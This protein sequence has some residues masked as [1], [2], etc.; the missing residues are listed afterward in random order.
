[1]DGYHEV[2]LK[3]TLNDILKKPRAAIF[4]TDRGSRYGVTAHN[5]RALII[6]KD[7]V[8]VA[9]KSARKNE[10]HAVNLKTALETNWENF[11]ITCA[12]FALMYYLIFA[13]FHSTVSKNICW[14]EV[15]SAILLT[16]E[17]LESLKDSGCDPYQIFKV[18]IAREEISS[19]TKKLWEKASSL[20]ENADSGQS[21]FIKSLTSNMAKSVL[22]KFNKDTDT[23]L[24]AK[25]DDNEKLP[26]TNRRA[27]SS[28][29]HLKKIMVQN[30]NLGDEKFAELG[31]AAVNSLGNWIREK[32]CE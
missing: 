13:P 27:E 10:Q 26:W 25:I 21:K 30:K 1:M 11:G 15:K 9:L 2:S 7:E 5:C 14:K 24:R 12:C 32:V 17:K 18:A 20:F 22:V 29:A 23:L 4:K 16:K 3:N 8:E 19:E 28:F 31:Q 6:F